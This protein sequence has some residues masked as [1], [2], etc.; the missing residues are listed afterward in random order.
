MEIERIE[1]G[2]DEGF[3][4]KEYGMVAGC[5]AACEEGA[6]EVYS[7]I[8]GNGTDAVAGEFSLMSMTSESEE[9]EGRPLHNR[10]AKADNMKFVP[11]PLSGDYIPLS[12]HTDLD[13]SQ[14]SYGTKSSTSGDS[15]YVSNDFVSCNNSDKSS[16]KQ[17]AISFDG[18]GISSREQL[19]TLL[20]RVTQSNQFVPQAEV[21]LRSGKV[22]FSVLD[23]T[24][25]A[26]N[27]NK[28]NLFSV[29]LRICTRRIEFSSQELI[30]CS[31]PMISKIPDGKLVLLR[32][33]K[34]AQSDLYRDKANQSADIFSQEL[35]KAEVRNKGATSD[36]DD[37]YNSVHFGDTMVSPSDVSVPTGGVLVPSGSPTDSF[38][39]AEPTTRFSSPS[40]LGNNVPS[41]GIFSSTSY[42][43]EFGADL[44][45]LASTVEVNKETITQLFKHCLVA[46][47][48]FFMLKPISVA[49][50]LEDPV[51]YVLG[52]S[53]YS[54]TRRMPGGLFIDKE[55]YVTQPKGFVDPQYPK[56]VYKV[57][58][59]LYGLHQAPKAC[60][61]SVQES[62]HSYLLQLE[63][64]KKIFN[65][66]AG[67]NKD[68][69]STTG[70]CQFQGRRLFSWN[71]RSKQLWLPLLLKLSMLLLL[72]DVVRHLMDLGLRK[73]LCLSLKNDMPPRDK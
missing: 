6:A 51:N 68:R 35:C 14:M 40:D 54:K 15:N 69:K 9:V 17:Y 8:T 2:N 22:L 66:Y 12:D 21:L 72:T 71:A 43:D 67:A 7:L 25:S 73:K 10:F 45:N 52:L 29:S 42:D 33:P 70:G 20:L 37:T 57:V 31:L 19:G 65:D 56:K 3:A 55:V 46:C 64:M 26:G 41:P 50:A 58:K 39:D 32:V 16:E 59:S 62:S 48:S 49:H 11:L 5:G 13:E 27:F 60:Q 1:S 53:G 44:N 28:F 30:V 18:V 38:F 24:G 63:A 4:P 61:C 36:A 34:E 23:Q 47:F